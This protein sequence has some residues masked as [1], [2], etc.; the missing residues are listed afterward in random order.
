VSIGTA[1]DLGYRCAPWTR[2][3][4]ADPIGSALTCDTLVLIETPPPWPR[5]VGEMP[6]FVDVQRRGPERTRLLAVRPAGD[7]AGEPGSVT[8]W[9]RGD[10]GRFVGTDHVVPAEGLARLIEDPQADSGRRTAPAEVLVCGHGTRDGCCGRMGTQLALHVARAWPGVRVRR[11][12]HTGGHRFA[13]TGFTLPD[14]R[15]WGF[16]D[17]EIL[18]A[19]VRRSGPPPLRGHYRGNTALDSWGQ[20]AERELFGRFGWSWLDCQVTS[21]STRVAPGGRSAAVELVW[22]GPA[23]AGQVGAGTA[24]AGTAIAQVDVVRDIPVLVCGEPPERAAKT[25]PDL[26]LRSI[27]IGSL[28]PGVCRLSAALI[29]RRECRDH[30]YRATWLGHPHRMRGGTTGDGVACGGQ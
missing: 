23:G 3:Q 7:E 11:C 21:S 4:G 29:I 2:A 5:D 26:A 13:P 16:L 20:V 14:G 1:P 17:A 25:A 18:D 6:A 15:A 8:I 28:P 30:A 24:G 27:S 9:R 22:R 10:S 19:I 12:S